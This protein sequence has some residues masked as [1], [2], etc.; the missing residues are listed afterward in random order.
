MNETHNP[1][2]AKNLT[3]KTFSGFIWTILGSATQVVLKI[4]VLAVL[5]RFVSPQ[6]FGVMTIALTVVDFSKRFTHMGVGPAIIQREVLEDRHLTT[7]FTLSLLMGIFFGFILF[8]TSPFIAD[9]FNM[10]QL[11]PVIK[12]ISLVFL[13]DSTTLIAQALLTR[14]MKFKINATYEVLSYAIGYG[15]VGIFLAYQGWGVWSLVAAHMVQAT[16]YTILLIYIQPFPKKLRLEWNAFKE[17]IFFG[18]GFTIA[19]LGN[20]LATQGDNLVV[21]RTLGAGALGI[22]GRAYQ[23]MVMPVGLFGNTLDKALFP[24]MAKVQNDK[25]RLAKAYLTGVGLIAF[26]SIP[27]G[28]IIIFLAHEIVLVILGETWKDV[29]LPLQILAGG[30]VFRMGYKMSDSLARAT[31]A[32]YQRA[33]RQFV[34][35]GL[36]ITGSYIGQF[37]GLYGVALGVVFALFSNFFMMTHLSLQ[38]TNLKWIE[39]FKIHLNGVVLGLIVGLVSYGLVW[40]CRLNTLPNLVTLVVTVLGVGGTIATIFY[41]FPHLLVNKELKEL[42]EKLILNKLKRF[43][44]K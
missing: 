13:I 29:I 14:N 4:G 18:G 22:Y 19:N 23:F 36:V 7:G 9:F 40:V 2:E 41:Y 3:G 30:L 20:Y 43:Q 32:V 31:G 28:V 35:A 21:G 37:W 11:T 38:L 12:V 42:F 33:W 8:I 15:A 27:L 25:L 44:K 1:S 16:V 24:A 26:I 10:E 5:V 39:I 17:L 34:F 6:E